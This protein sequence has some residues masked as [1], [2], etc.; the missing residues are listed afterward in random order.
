M[1]NLLNVT[2]V[3]RKQRAAALK[4]QWAARDRVATCLLSSGSRL[5][6]CGDG[7]EDQSTGTG[8]LACRETNYSRSAQCDTTQKYCA[9]I[10]A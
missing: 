5:N 1:A 8:R 10:S 2:H 9:N 3:A 7:V 6:N 4:D